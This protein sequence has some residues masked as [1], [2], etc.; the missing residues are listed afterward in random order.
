MKRISP[1]N[2]TRAAVKYKKNNLKCIINGVLF[3]RLYRTLAKLFYVSSF[4]VATIKTMLNT[5]AK[6]VV[7]STVG[8]FVDEEIFPRSCFWQW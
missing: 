2:F 8:G 6:A 5:A 3:N 4:T 7:V 1:E